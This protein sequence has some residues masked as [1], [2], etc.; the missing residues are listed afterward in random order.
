MTPENMENLLTAQ[1]F[2]C[3][4]CGNKGKAVKR[5]TIESLLT[6]EA[7]ALV[8]SR[9]GF[10]FC[11]TPTCEVSYFHPQTGERFLCRDVR[12]RIGQ[13]QTQ[14]PRP[15]CYCFNHT[16]EEIEAEVAKT[17]TSK[18]PD[19]ITE[20]C[21][22]GLDRCEQTNPQ[23]S[24]CIADVRR[25][26]RE[27][28]AKFG[29]V[30]AEVSYSNENK[31]VST[32]DC[33]ANE[34]PLV[35][36]EAEFPRNVGLW[37]TAGAVLSAILS[38]ACCWLPLLLI[39]FGASAAGV[40][41]FFEAYRPY[42]L[43]AT[44]LLLAGGFYLVYFRKERCEPGSTCAV[45]SPRLV[46]FNKVMLL[47]ATVVVLLFA[48]FPNYLGFLIGSD[49]DNSP[50]TALTGEGHLFRIEGM[51]CEGCAVNLQSHL[52]RVP[53][54]THAEVSYKSKTARLF[55]DTRVAPPSDS[56]IQEAIKQA[57]YQGSP[58][59]DGRILDI[60]HGDNLRQVGH[61]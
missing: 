26:L 7:K 39:A 34:A 45:P 14:A 28:Q 31:A 29:K 53:G 21:H 3:P 22:Q 30:P 52:V 56:K 6:D 16:I 36:A 37:A 9:D 13:K 55:F 60:G 59:P 54:V 49:K 47:V 4:S 46:R 1:G 44:G 10:R 32:A 35:E 5:I 25:V 12:V 38:S 24:C 27:A 41:G 11:P 50:V 40:S 57:G 23:G 17:G 20:K 8:S 15:I 61:Y 19:A 51:T 33:C 48:L 43:G 58:V 2:L 18:I 42:L